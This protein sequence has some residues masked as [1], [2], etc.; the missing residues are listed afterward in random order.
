MAGMIKSIMSSTNNGSRTYHEQIHV[1]YLYC[2]LMSIVVVI[3]NLQPIIL[4]IIIM[5]S[6]FSTVHEHY[7]LIN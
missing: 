4:I 5:Y 3:C 6:T 7:N 1:Q 2:K